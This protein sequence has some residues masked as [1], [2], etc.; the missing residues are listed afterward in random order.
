[1]RVCKFKGIIFTVIPPPVDWEG[2]KVKRKAFEIVSISNMLNIRT[3][4]IP[5]VI[6]EKDGKGRVVPYKPKVDNVEFGKIL[7]GFDGN[8]DI[9][10]DKVVPLIPKDLLEDTLLSISKEFKGITL[11]GGESSKKV[12]PGFSPLE[13]VGF[14]IGIR[15]S[16]TRRPAPAPPRT[17][18]PR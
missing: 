3:I 9:I 8:L 11:V 13:A 5:E 6:E 17:R 1:M 2:E 7:K 10:I 18:T 12:Y 14:G 16:L 4:N 15:A